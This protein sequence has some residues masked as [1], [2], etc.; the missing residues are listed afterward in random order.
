MNLFINGFSKDGYLNV[1]DKLEY[2][3]SLKNEGNAVL[4]DMISRVIMNDENDLIDWQTLKIEEEGKMDNKE[5]SWN[6][7]G[8]GKLSSLS[9]GENIDLHFSLNLKEKDFIDAGNIIDNNLTSWAEIKIGMTGDLKTDKLL[10]SNSVNMTLNT[11]WDIK[12]EA[13]YFNE[14]G[15][16]IGS[17]PL[18]PRVGET[19][20]YKIRWSLKADLN[21]VKEIKVKATLPKDIIWNDKTDIE[22][23]ELYFNYETR[24]IIWAV[25]TLPRNPK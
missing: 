1:G 9:P 5:I 13:R 22:T 2:L 15:Q 6:S 18:P 17:G 12:S 19:T 14:D 3:L 7:D 25:P 16:P 24:E 10:K 8:Y 23:G 21:D 4:G 20:S 11:L